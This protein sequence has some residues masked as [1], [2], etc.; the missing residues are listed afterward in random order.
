MKIYPTTDAYMMECAHFAATYG[1]TL[2]AMEVR[3][4]ADRMIVWD[5]ERGGYVERDGVDF[6][7][8]AADVVMA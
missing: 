8:V 1:A 3:Q 2:A 7:D 5:A 6:W 4:I